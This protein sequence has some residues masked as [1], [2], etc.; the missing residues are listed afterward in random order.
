MTINVG[1]FKEQFSS[2]EALVSQLN[3]ST[4]SFTEVR[5]SIGSRVD[6]VAKIMKESGLF[7][8]ADVLKLEDYGRRVLA[9]NPKTIK[10]DTIVNLISEL[11]V[12]KENVV[13][14]LDFDQRIPPAVGNLVRAYLPAEEAVAMGEVSK[15]LESHV[16]RDSQLGKRI[17]AERLARQYRLDGEFGEDNSVEV[18]K[19]RVE[20]DV[21]FL[22]KIF[23]DL[24]IP[25]DPF[26]QLLAFRTEVTYSPRPLGVIFDYCMEL[27]PAE[28]QLN[29]NHIGYALFDLQIDEQFVIST[30]PPEILQD[31]FN[32]ASLPLLRLAFQ[33]D[34]QL[35]SPKFLLKLQKMFSDAK[36]SGTGVDIDNKM[37]LIETMLKKE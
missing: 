34:P 23:P 37:A 20:N 14:K 21:A 32:F 19:Q 24:E 8:P 12:L 25:A 31:I 13:Q 33:R 7:S 2:L 5:E 27:S 36:T 11:S 15:I 17:A 3:S 18:V 30:L 16:E 26:E 4:E 10:S 28:R 29:A 22:R 6:N 1:N 35:T 9:I